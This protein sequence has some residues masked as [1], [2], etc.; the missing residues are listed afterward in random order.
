LIE[1]LNDINNADEASGNVAHSN[2][3]LAIN[4][5]EII[6][7]DSGPLG[8]LKNRCYSSSYWAV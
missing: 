2:I 5:K 4:G 7:V 1:I 8:M 3:Y 6:V